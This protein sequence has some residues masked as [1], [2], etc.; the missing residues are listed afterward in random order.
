MWKNKKLNNSAISLRRALREYVCGILY[1]KKDGSYREA[2]GTTYIDCIVP[3]SRPKGKIKHPDRKSIR[4]Y[5]LEKEEWRSLKRTHLV[6][7]WKIKKL[8]DLTPD[9][10]NCRLSSACY[11]GEI[12]QCPDTLKFLEWAGCGK[13][14]VHPR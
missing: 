12:L 4:Y 2:V 5:D 7:Y 14:V 6:G 13:E 9:C 1:V 10:E 11:F 8:S 3:H